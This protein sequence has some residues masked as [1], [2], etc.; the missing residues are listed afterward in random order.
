MPCPCCLPAVRVSA[1]DR[2]ALHARGVRCVDITAMGAV[3]RRNQLPHARARNLEYA[4]RGQWRRENDESG[5]GGCWHVGVREL[6]EAFGAE[7]VREKLAEYAAAQAVARE[8]AIAAAVAAIQAE[9][10][11][12]EGEEAGE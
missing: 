7:S 3:A 6:V 9:K 2:P 1:A 10:E 4:V 11:E 12:E 5:E 8:D